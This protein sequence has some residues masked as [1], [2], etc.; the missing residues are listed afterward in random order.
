MGIIRMNYSH[1]PHFMSE[2]F[3]PPLLVC[4]LTFAAALLLWILLPEPGMPETCGWE[5][6]ALGP[7]TEEEL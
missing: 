6:L 1:S 4:L 3:S 7:V 5:G 2:L